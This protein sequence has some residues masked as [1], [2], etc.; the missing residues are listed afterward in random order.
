MVKSTGKMTSGRQG[1]MNASYTLRKSGR[2]KR[3][4]LAVHCDGS[5]V[6]TAPQDAAMGVVERFIADKKRWIQNK[7]EFFK[8]LDRRVVCG[9]SKK[10]YQEHKHQARQLAHER[11]N[12]FNELYQFSFNRISIKNQKTRWGS[13]SIKK[14]LN[15]NYKIV[16]LPKA[17]Q[18]YI[19]V[20]ELC[21]LK[22]MNHSPRFWQLVQRALP[23]CLE[24]RKK[25]KG[26]IPAAA[27]KKDLSPLDPSGKPLNQS[28]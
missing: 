19:I 12:H 21:H 18:D 15:I 3:M 24:T 14:N 6:V 8:A 13:C 22:E 9:G 25:L 16:F 28:V 1:F 26:R 2:A 27:G 4:R 23:D 7:L 20:H 17:M 10:E 5:V 11:V